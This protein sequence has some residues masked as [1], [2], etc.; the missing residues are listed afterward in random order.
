[1]WGSL[2]CPYYVHKALM[3]LCN[4]PADKVRVVQMET[5]ELLAARKNIPR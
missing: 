1:M 5:G 2:Q 4:L 3:A